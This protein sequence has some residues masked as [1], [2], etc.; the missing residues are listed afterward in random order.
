MHA[1]AHIEGKDLRGHEIDQGERGGAREDEDGAPN[2]CGDAV[3]EPG[4]DREETAP[5]NGH[6]AALHEDVPAKNGLGYVVDHRLANGL[7][8]EEAVKGKQSGPAVQ[9]HHPAEARPELVPKDVPIPFVKKEMPE[10]QRST[11]MHEEC[12]FGLRRIDDG[13]LGRRTHDGGGRKDLDLLLKVVGEAGHQKHHV[14]GGGLYGLF[15]PRRIVRQ[16][17]PGTAHP[18]ALPGGI[19]NGHVLRDAQGLGERLQWVEQGIH[20][21]RIDA[22]H[23][24]PLLGQGLGGLLQV[25]KEEVWPEQEG[26]QAPVAGGRAGLLLVGWE[27]EEPHAHQARDGKQDANDGDH[28]AQ[29]WCLRPAAPCPRRGLGAASR[30]GGPSLPHGGGGEGMV[31]DGGGGGGGG[32]ALDEGRRLGPPARR[33]RHRHEPVLVGG[34]WG[35]GGYDARGR[36]KCLVIIDQGNHRDSR[37][38]LGGGALGG[39]QWADGGWGMAGRQDMLFAHL[40]VPFP[41]QP[42]CGVVG[43]W[44]VRSCAW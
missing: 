11:R 37:W 5:H 2:F 44:Q 24:G 29:A 4:H 9:V 21:V 13:P 26:L 16:A 36:T 43:V 19:E 8:G 42:A 27:G 38:W 40:A 34:W 18:K 20:P 12:P 28:E 39:A 31:D 25:P 7:D 14:A 1:H 32:G 35:R 3:D 17:G 30:H 22:R 41:L 15:E 10:V 23:G 33:A 6:G